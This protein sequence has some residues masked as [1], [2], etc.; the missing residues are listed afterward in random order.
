MAWL[1]LG[2]LDKASRFVDR[3]RRGRVILKVIRVACGCLR[4]GPGVL[5]GWGPSP[6]AFGFPVA[7]SGHPGLGTVPPVS[8]A[9]RKYRD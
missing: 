6:K 1:V 4:G 8:R 2:F 7:L 5:P 3:R 9:D